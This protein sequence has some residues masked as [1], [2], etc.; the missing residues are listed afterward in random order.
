[1]KL[2]VVI[3]VYNEKAILEEIIRCIQATPTEKE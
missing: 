3:P 2:P 1:M